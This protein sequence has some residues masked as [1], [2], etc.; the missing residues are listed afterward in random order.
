MGCHFIRQGILSTQG[1]NLGLLHWQIYSL[2][3]SHLG[4]SVK[5]QVAINYYYPRNDR[6]LTYIGILEIMQ[7]GAQLVAQ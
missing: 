6:M 4:S 2:P 3:L 5:A 1:L 7:L